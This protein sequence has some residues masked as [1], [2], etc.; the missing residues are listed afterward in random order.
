MENINVRYGLS[1]EINKKQSK[2]LNSKATFLAKFNNLRQNGEKQEVIKKIEMWVESNIDKLWEMS[3][4]G[5]HDHE[6]H[7]EDTAFMRKLTN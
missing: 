6:K 5:N 2:F 4:D 1:R 7:L 3:Q